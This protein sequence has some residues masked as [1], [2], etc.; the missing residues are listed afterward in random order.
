L[1]QLEEAAE[2]NRCQG[3]ARTNRAQ[4]EIQFV[5][6]AGHFQVRPRTFACSVPDPASGKHSLALAWHPP[7]IWRCVWTLISAPVLPLR[8]E[9]CGGLWRQ[10]SRVFA[11]PAFLS[12]HVRPSKFSCSSLDFQ[13]G[14]GIAEGP[15]HHEK[16]VRFGVRSHS[17][18]IV[19]T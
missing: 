6:C 5:E 17:P 9:G 7:G 14:F 19:S 15:R 18:T 4:P 11:K 2:C 12:L 1:A 13:D 3:V 10:K 8:A 16:P